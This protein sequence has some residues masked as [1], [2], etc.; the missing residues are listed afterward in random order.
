MEV[1][2]AA[3]LLAEKVWVVHNMVVGET[4][5]KFFF[6]INSGMRKKIL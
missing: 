1:F 6:D 2:I 3:E 4:K 5:V